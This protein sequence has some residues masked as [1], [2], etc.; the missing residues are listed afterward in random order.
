MTDL[1]EISLSTGTTKILKF[2]S[3]AFGFIMILTGVFANHIGLSE[4][5]GIGRAQII[6]AVLGTLFILAGVLGRAFMRVYRLFSRFILM[7]I[8]LT[9]ILELVSTA[10]VLIKT[11][12]KRLHSDFVLELAPGLD[13][14][15]YPFTGWRCFTPDSIKDPDVLFLGGSALALPRLDSTCSQFSF[16]ADSAFSCNGYTIS[17]YSQPFY[18][19]TQSF[20]QLI[21]LLRNGLHP[22]SV[23]LI[24]GPGD[25]LAAIESGTPMIPL[26]TDVYRAETWSGLEG[27]VDLG[28]LR[29]RTIQREAGLPATVTVIH[30][31]TGDDNK[32]YSPFTE[33]PDLADEKLD[34]L[35][36]T[37]SQMIIAQCETMDA[38]AASFSF[39]GRIIWLEANPE[40]EFADD[41]YYN[42][43]VR[44][45]ILIS[46]LADSIEC[47]STVRY[48]ACVPPASTGSGYSG[49]DKYQCIPLINS[50]NELILTASNR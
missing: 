3:L 19:S 49:L 26:G 10:L 15:Y 6:L 28:E 17:D 12:E 43:H 8:L 41:P 38:L 50:I 35:A 5:A 33:T 36:V 39:D 9:C 22:S 31:L 37:I 1:K 27:A 30:D 40:Q 29:R 16:L 32:H 2:S 11:R 25:I 13:C 20:I 4:G 21:L 48:N 42:L 34:S 7:L 14:L 46:E 24:S 23:F 47:L 18:S 45:S 44:T